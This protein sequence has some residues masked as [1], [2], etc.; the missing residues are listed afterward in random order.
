MMP[1]QK[2]SPPDEV[3][4][5][6]ACQQD[7]GAWLPSEQDYFNVHFP[8]S[9]ASRNLNINALEM[10]TLIMA[11]KMWG[12]LWRGLRIVIQCDNKTSVTV[13]N[14]DRTLS[15]SLQGCLRELELVAAR[16]EFQ[17]RAVHI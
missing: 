14:T 1:W 4:A 12:K 7:C 9:I 2:W 8:E 6:D 3:V 16:C 13:L 5:T 11:A 15:S 17:L 10:L